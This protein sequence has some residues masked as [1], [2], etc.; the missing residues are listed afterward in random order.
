MMRDLSTI[1]SIEDCHDLL[2]IATVDDHNRR[3]AL[4]RK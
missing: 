3:I 2:E 4:K 1:L